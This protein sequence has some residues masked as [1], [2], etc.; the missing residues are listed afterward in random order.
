M[1]YFNT[2]PIG[3]AVTGTML[4]TA[5]KED[6][7]NIWGDG[8]TFK[9][10]DIERFYRY[11][12]LVNPSLKIYKPWLDAAFIDELGGRAEMSEFMQAAGFAYKMSAEKAYSTDSNLLGA[13]HE[14][15]DLEQLS[16]SV[17]IVVPIMGTAFW[18]DDIEIKRE[19]ITVRFEEGFPV[20][21]N[22]RQF[23]DPVELL[24]EANRIGGR[25]G[26]GMSDQIENRIIEAKSRGIYEAPGLALLFIAYERLITGIH[27]EDTIEQYRDNGRKLGRLLYQGRW[28]DSQ[29]IMLRESAQRWVAKPITGEVT[30]ELRRGNDYSILNTESPNLTF[31]PERLSMEK[32]EST[33]SPRDRIGQL[34]MRNLDITDTRDKLMTYAAAGLLTLSTGNEM[35]LLSSANEKDASKK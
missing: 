20:A 31:H 26:L 12:L 15:K 3:R 33:F 4:V 19:E 22:G 11:G 7:V 13:T 2:T 29:S 10:N 24:L 9:G 17:K 30:L 34:T 8:S 25:H 35:P 27:N 18:R 28:F 1:P 14:A 23:S 16:S 6:D 21:L 5:M 32:T